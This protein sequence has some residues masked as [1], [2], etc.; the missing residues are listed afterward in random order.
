MWLRH[1]A[2][3]NYRSL[4]DFSFNLTPLTIL[5]GPNNSG[6]SNILRA[7]AFL[8][9]TSAQVEDADV[10]H[11]SGSQVPTLKEDTVVYVEGTFTDL[12]NDEKKT[13]SKYVSPDGEMTVRRQSTY[14]NASW[15][16]EYRGVRWEPHIDWMRSDAIDTRKLA[17]RAELKKLIESDPSAAPLQSILDKGGRIPKEAVVQ[18][19]LDIRS[20]MH[21]SLTFQK[22]FEATKFMGLTNVGGGLL[23]E[24]LFLPAV[25]ELNDESATRTSASFGR[26]MRYAVQAMLTSDSRIQNVSADMVQALSDLNDRSDDR[27]QVTVLESLENA[28]RDELG[29]WHDVQIRIQVDAPSIEQVFNLGSQMFV[30]DGVETPADQKGH[31]LQRALV[32]ALMRAWTRHTRESGE[33][34]GRQGRSRN[35]S[36]IYGIE[37]PELS[38]HPHAQRSLARDLR[39]ISLNGQSQVVLTTHSSQFVDMEHYSEIGILAISSASGESEIRQCSYDIFDLEEAQADRRRFQLSEWIDATRGE[40]FFSKGVVL[41]EGPTEKAVLPLIAERICVDIS[42]ISIVDC[43]GKNN[44]PAYCR[45]LNAFQIPYMLIH[46]EDP[47]RDGLNGDKLRT[48][49]NL[50]RCNCRIADAVDER[51]GHVEVVKPEFDSACGVSRSAG[52]SKGKPFAAVQHLADLQEEELPSWLCD[53]VGRISDIGSD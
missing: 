51:L 28:I 13:F 16:T 10:F 9:D 6:K 39:R 18:G 45:V 23:P 7:I 52:K 2:I 31:G 19:I 17:L 11:P 32:F 4:R 40:L 26:L 12:S 22:E 1:V 14:A 5:L 24:F 8:L 25:R 34:R 50:F 29:H 38:L 37:E 35:L 21:D 42:E 20:D 48:A 33:K 41:V 15:T 3:H 53:L 44:L 27:E 49:E 36:L 43:A 30:D 47:V 46:D